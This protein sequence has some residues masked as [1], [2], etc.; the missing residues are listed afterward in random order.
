MCGQTRL[1]VTLR[2]AGP[3]DDA[4]LFELFIS[5]KE[6]EFLSIP[7]AIRDTFA[8]QQ[9]DIH[10][11]GTEA[12][13]PDAE[14]LIVEVPVTENG[15]TVPTAAGRIS[16]DRTDERLLVIDLAIHPAH[17]NG[18]LGTA[19]LELLME[20]CRRDGRIL[21]GSVTP[22]NP[23][24]RLYARLGIAEL[25]SGNGYLGLEWRPD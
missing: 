17:R 15:M 14:H 2:P 10:R 16:I 9:F 21:R 7:A 19:V 18:G 5:S 13:Y 11:L 12:T 1:T 20:Q 22:Y 6:R 24:R 25:P 23:A 3:S 4:F 8:R